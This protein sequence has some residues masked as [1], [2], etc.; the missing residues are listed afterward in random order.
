VII[1]GKTTNIG[2]ELSVTKRKK[3][4]VNLNCDYWESFNKVTFGIGLKNRD[5]NYL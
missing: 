2:G 1:V 4:E 3:K 5:F